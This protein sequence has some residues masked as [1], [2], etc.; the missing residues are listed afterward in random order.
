MI[1]SYRDRRTRELAAGGWVREL[2]SI[3]RRAQMRLDQ[4][5]AATCIKD[6]ALPGNRLKALSGGRAGQLSMRIN[7]QWRVCFEWPKGS[8]GPINVEIVD[9]H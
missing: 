8:K 2:Q 1:V 4:L 3:S 9:Y 5:D 6:L 7:D